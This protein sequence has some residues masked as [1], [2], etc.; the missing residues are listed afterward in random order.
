[1]LKK[2]DF[3]SDATAFACIK[4]HMISYDVI[5]LRHKVAMTKL[6]ISIKIHLLKEVSFAASDYLYT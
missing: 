6:Q 1:M 3:A 2:V 4:D 5:L